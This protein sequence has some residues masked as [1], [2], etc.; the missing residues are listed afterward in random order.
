[1]RNVGNA[2][3][4]ADSANIRLLAGNRR[5]LVVLGVI[6]LP[7]V[8]LVIIIVVRLETYIIEH[9]TEDLTANVLNQLFRPAHDVSRALSPMDHKQNA[10]DHSRDQDA[11]SK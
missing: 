11:I 4:L 5:L 1:M 2:A 9:H 3:G 6:L 10:I 8:A 7:V